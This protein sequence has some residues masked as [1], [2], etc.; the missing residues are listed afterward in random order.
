MCSSGVGILLTSSTDGSVAASV[1]SLD[2]TGL[3][4]FTSVQPPPLSVHFVSIKS[5]LV[6]SEL[7]LVSL[8]ALV[9]LLML[10]TFGGCVGG[11]VCCVVV[12]LACDVFDFICDR[13]SDLVLC[14]H[15]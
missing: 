10:V 4:S 14:D 8:P 11:F 1:D 15:N 13:Q 12:G 7:F 2:S 6:P 9:L 5:G 3:E